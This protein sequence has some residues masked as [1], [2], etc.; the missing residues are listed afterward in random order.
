MEILIFLVLHWFASLFFQTFFHHRYAAHR[1]FTMSRFWEK[2]FFV[3]SFLAQGASYLKPSAYAIL[4]RQ[5]HAH[6]D[7]EKDPHSP[8]FSRDV[9]SMMYRTKVLYHDLVR[10]TSEEPAPPEWESFDRMAD[11]MYIRILWGVL[12]TTFYFHY[13]TN[14][15]VLLLLPVHYLMGVFHGAIV[16]WCGHKY[17][18]RTFANADHS[19]NTLVV[20]LLMFGELYQNNHHKFPNRANFAYRWFEFDPVYPFVRLFHSMRIIQLGP[21][22]LNT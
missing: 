13:M 3:F 9:M 4:H 8:H 16:N 10:S 21:L 22:A 2:C 14:F 18:Y 5:H 6:S 20:D 7:T 1:M 11:S 19:R 12:Y 17:G 15:W